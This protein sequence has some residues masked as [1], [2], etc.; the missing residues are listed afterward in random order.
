MLKLKKDNKAYLVSIEIA[1]WEA[2][3]N[4]L[5]TSSRENDAAG[6]LIAISG[7]FKQTQGSQ[8]VIIYNVSSS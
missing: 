2:D 6:G 4:L 7:G 8:H 5:L 3:L 1:F